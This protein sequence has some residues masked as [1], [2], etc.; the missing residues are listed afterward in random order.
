MP[1][2]K[3][4]KKPTTYLTTL[5]QQEVADK[6]ARRA[7]LK[8]LFA[9]SNRFRIEERTTKKKERKEYLNGIKKD[10][11]ALKVETHKLLG[12]TS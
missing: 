9:E 1:T 6:K 2:K 7:Y 4:V 5:K 10:L 11:A 3:K 12:R 8:N